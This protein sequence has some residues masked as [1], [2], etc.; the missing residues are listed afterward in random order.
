V[1]LRRL[2]SI[3]LRVINV[4]VRIFGALV[5]FLGVGFLLI[6]WFGQSDRI[7]YGLVGMLGIATGVAS[8]IAK[9]ISQ[10]QID[11]LRERSRSDGGS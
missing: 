10:P 3:A 8:W 7:V 1:S 2:D 4:G 5:A 9:P 6:A 11:S